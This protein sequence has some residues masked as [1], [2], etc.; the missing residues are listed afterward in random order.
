MSNRNSSYSAYTQSGNSYAPQNDQ[1]S[2]QTLLN[3]LHNSHNSGTPLSLE[4]STGVVINAWNS[5]GLADGRQR[6]TI[7]EQIARRA[8]E[9]VRRRAEDGCVVLA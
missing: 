3:A 9:H 7:D 1:V 5:T 8:W 2:T 4:S 6:P